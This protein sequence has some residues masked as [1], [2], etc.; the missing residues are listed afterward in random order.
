MKVYGKVQ[1]SLGGPIPGA[2][3]MLVGEQDSILKSFAVTNKEGLFTLT[4]VK[5]DHYVF[6]VNFSLN[7]YYPVVL[8]LYF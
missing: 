6:K 1:D 2:T 3:V 4:N 5:P 7:N 8:G